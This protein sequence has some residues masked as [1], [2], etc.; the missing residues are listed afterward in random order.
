MTA[1]HKTLPFGTLL[2]LCLDGCVVQSYY[3]DSLAP[4]GD[5]SAAKTTQMGDSDSLCFR[6]CEYIEGTPLTHQ[7]TRHVLPV[8]L[9]RLILYLDL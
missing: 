6:D 8:S 1:A 3:K 7:T 2:K 9:A 5:S 4:L